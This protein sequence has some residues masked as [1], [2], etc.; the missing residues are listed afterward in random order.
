[1]SVMTADKSSWPLILPGFEHISRF[2]DSTHT[3]CAAKILPGEFY[4][5][6]HAEMI[7]TVLGSCISACIRDPI[8]GVG[9]MNHF[10]L[11]GN[12]KQNHDK[13]GGNDCLETRYGV[14]AMESLVNEILKLGARKER[15]ELKFFG[16]GKVLAMEINNI[17]ERNIS[18]AKEFAKIEG[19]PVIA[20][21]L[22]GPHPRKVNYFPRTGKVMIRR[23][24]SMQTKAVVAQ[25]KNYGATMS[26]RE[27]PGEIELF[28]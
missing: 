15:L 28:G 23:L 24:R 7:T 6:Q 11:P 14:A 21:D 25:E 22:G 10:M 16:A 8:T 13:W 4:V 2:W 18:F 17:G 20:E 5:T 9:G 3:L 1:M 12:N 19:L 27:K 26:K